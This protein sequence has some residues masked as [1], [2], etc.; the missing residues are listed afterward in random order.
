MEIRLGKFE[1]K[2]T[3]RR[4]WKEVF[5][6]DEFYLDYKFSETF[7]PLCTC[8]AYDGEIVGMVHF[9]VYYINSQKV[10]YINGV[11]VLPSFRRKKLATKMLDFVHIYLKSQGFA[12]CFLKPAISN[13]YESFGYVTVT[14]GKN[15]TIPKKSN[16]DYTTDETSYLEIYREK[17]KLSDV[18]I[19]RSVENFETLIG[20]YKNY[21]G[22]IVC[23]KKNNKPV[24]YCLYYPEETGIVIEEF[25]YSDDICLD[26]IGDY[27]GQNVKINELP[28]MVKPLN[29]NFDFEKPFIKVI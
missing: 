23:F 20:L 21:G 15:F 14:E 2:D 7:S 12:Y 13:F 11:S 3:L 10:A 25:V 4:I 1:E 5:N 9:D 17:C 26:F 29:S 8:V 27:F 16:N 6:E 22:G 24:G 19:P 18:Y 28:V